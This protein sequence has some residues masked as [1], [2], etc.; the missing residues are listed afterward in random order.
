MCGISLGCGKLSPIRKSHMW[1]LKPIYWLFERDP[2][3]ASDRSI[4]AVIAQKGGR[5]VWLGL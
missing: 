3:D 1:N 5:L 4:L 2:G